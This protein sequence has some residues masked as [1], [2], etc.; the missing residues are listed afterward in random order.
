VNILK[1]QKYDLTEGPIFNKLFKLSV[2]IMATSLMQTAHSLANMFWLSWLGE[3]YVAAAGLVGQ[4]LW[5]SFSLIMLCRIGAEIGVSQNMG[6]NEP[7]AA[8]SFAQ[9]GFVLAV[10]L[11]TVVAI[12]A[13]IFRV[14][15]LRF[16]NIESEYVA[17]VA[18]QYMAVAVLSLPFTFGHFVITGVYGGFGNTKIPFYINSAALLLNIVLSPIFIFVLDLGVIGAAMALVAAA[19]FNFL[20]KIWA[21]TKYKGRP[22]EQY[23]PFV[24]LAMDKIKQILRWGVPVAAES[25][26]FTMLF[27]LVTRLITSF[28]DGAVAA[29]QIGM[30]IESLSFMIGGGFASALTAFVGQNFGAKKW[31]RLRST[32]KVG[33]IFMGIYGVGITL[34]L[35]IFARPLVSIF[36]RQPESITIA[37]N[38]L[39]IIGLAQLLFCLEG[40]ATGSFRGR[41]LTMKPT[42]SSV[43]SNII[44]V[45]ACYALAA[46]ALGITGIWWGIFIAM[47]IRSTITLTWHRVNIRE[48]PKV[49]EEPSVAE[50]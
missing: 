32:F 47:T 34:I 10:I 37:A 8:K 40:V 38:Y 36:L 45:I 24:W 11:G 50:A 43:T 19:I 20:V 25:A 14:T 30:Q 23:A 21:M 18:Q 5:L 2:P 9:N 1:T 31:G 48:L 39:R 44:R 6:K 12:P 16:F 4:F 46:T 22:F 29:H 7:E 41:G 15:L 49:D 17:H 28:G 27:M 42:V 3:G 13:I 33:Y 35:F 26:L